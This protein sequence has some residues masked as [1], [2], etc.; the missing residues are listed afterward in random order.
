MKKPITIGVI[1]VIATILV[2][3]TI[4]YS[5]IGAKP[6][7]QIHLQLGHGVVDGVLNCPDANT[8]LTDQGGLGFTE[9]VTEDASGQTFNVFESYQSTENTPN[10]SWRWNFEYSGAPVG[11]QEGNTF[12]VT[13]FDNDS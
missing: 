11:E 13:C 6:V 3:S 1:T 5:A 4:D 12:H 2:S 10:D 9:H 8:L 7:D